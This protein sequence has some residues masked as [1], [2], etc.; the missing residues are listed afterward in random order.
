MMWFDHPKNRHYTGN[1]Q[2]GFIEGHG[3]MMYSDQSTYTGWWRN[4]M[5]HRHGR[6]EYKHNN[7][8][9]SGGWEL[10]KRCG[11]GVLDNKEK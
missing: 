4:G 8:T 5:R 11:Y 10:D 9:Y 2:G 6:M 1:W 3:E 7:C